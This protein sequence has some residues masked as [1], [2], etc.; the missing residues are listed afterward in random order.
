MRVKLL[1]KMAG[2]DGCHSQ[3]EVIDVS[4]TVAASLI[5]G[6]FAVRV[7]DDPPV[8]EHAVVAPDETRAMK[9]R[10]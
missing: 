5:C 10:K 2:P 9:R 1:T 8:V 3:G 7:D 4:A 6:E